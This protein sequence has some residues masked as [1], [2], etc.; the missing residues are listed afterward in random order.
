MARKPISGRTAGGYSFPPYY[1]ATTEDRLSIACLP[2]ELYEALEYGYAPGA[3]NARQV[4]LRLRGELNWPR[5]MLT[6]FVGVSREV[7]RRGETGERN[8]CGTTRRFTIN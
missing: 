2:G 8:P 4:L 6:A 7:M 3:V 5:S 1:I